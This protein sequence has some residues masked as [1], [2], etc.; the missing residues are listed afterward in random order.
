MIEQHLKNYYF[1][2]EDNSGLINSIKVDMYRINKIILIYF[3][4]NLLPCKIIAQVSSPKGL[5][6]F[7]DAADLTKASVGTNLILIGA[8]QSIAGPAND[9]GA[10]RI[11]KGSYYKLNHG[12]L[13]N[14]G[15]SLVNE[16]TL[17]I[18]FKITDLS[19]WR[20]FFQTSLMNN[21][22]AECFIDLDGFVGVQATGYSTFK[23][24]PDE[25]YRLVISVKNGTHYKYYIDGQQI[26]NG[27]F[28]AIDGRFALDKTFLFFADENGE[29]GEIDCSEIAIWNYAL[30]SQEVRTLGGF[31]H[32]T[33]KVVLIPYLQT[34]TENSMVVCW[35][36]TL[37]TKSQVEY[38]TSPA[39]ENVAHGS[40]EIIAEDFIWHTVELTGLQPNTEYFYKAISGSGASKIYSFKTL[41]S[42]NYKGKIRFLLLSDTHS[43][44]TSATVNVI[45]EAKKKMEQL[46]GDD[47]H[48]QINF[49]LHSGDLVVTGSEIT[50]WTDQYFAPMSLI[51]P[52]LATMTIPGNHE[53]EGSIY[54]SYMKHE[55]ISAYPR[56]D[57]LNEKFWSFNVAN[58]CIIGLNSNLTNS[59]RSHQTNWLNE[60]LSQ[61]ELDSKIDFVFIIVHHLPI[62]ELWG[63]GISDAGSVYVK[64]QIIPI[65]KKYSKIVQLSYGHTHGFERG[66]IESESSSGKGDF[67]IV[68]GGGGGG[69]LDIWGIFK[70]ADFHPIHIA[71]DHYGY[72]LIE[73]DVAQKTFE[74]SFYSLGNIYKKRDS[75]LLDKW[76]K[77]IDQPA[78]E[79]P[80][81]FHP[82]FF[83]STIKFTS[84]VI[85]QD[86]LMTVRIQVAEDISLKK[87]V[88]DTLFHWKNIYGVDPNYHPVDLNKGIDLTKISMSCSP[89]VN[90]KN[91]YYRVR[92]RDHNLSWS[93]WSNTVSFQLPPDIEENTL[94]TQYD[95][96]QNFPNPF[97]S[98]TKI[99]YQIPKSGIVTIKVFDLLGREIITLVNAFKNAGK[100]ETQFDGSFLSSGIYFYQLQVGNYKQIKKLI[101]LR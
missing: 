80:E 5:W 75:E 30:S 11:S 61:I 101:L 83:P 2:C 59:K 85:S 68:C 89:F 65:L 32:A 8:H 51:S 99:I 47:F 43:S 31:G 10:I 57:P 29:D 22:D 81:A 54:Y 16:Y 86:S 46:Y 38:G 94:I 6:T 73:I 100:Y 95:L 52:T 82:D 28:Q 36:D 96:K 58:V 62:S 23:I 50:H 48:N 27:F 97:N 63:E 91:Y 64:N 53:G 33:K 20:S 26:L 25:W 92:F 66:T 34:P 98:L 12:F 39:L 78:P 45:S 69:P 56:L 15:G 67:R 41:P 44:D 71:L 13:P 14:G 49:V 35:H 87:I 42:S 7:N 9:N 37:T 55:N 93:D 70:N 1:L 4:I 77:K 17:L 88:V 84:S 90:E 60:K 19:S 21:N 24:K 79:K 74:S 3:L 40:S 72:Q 76:Y 18:D